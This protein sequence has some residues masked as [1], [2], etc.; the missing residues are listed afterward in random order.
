MRNRVG[1]DQSCFVCSRRADGAA[2][3]SGPGPREALGWFCAD[4]G[5][6]IA[7]EAIDMSATRF[8]ALEQAAIAK[9]AA[10]LKDGR[11][12][13]VT[14][15]R[16]EITLFVG[17]VIESFAETMRDTMKGAQPETEKEK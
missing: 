13:D 4:C 12:D 3:S 17:W 8:D 10:E 9:I 15:P 5:A 1:N 2:V 6:D 16:E 11:P 7:R 14:I